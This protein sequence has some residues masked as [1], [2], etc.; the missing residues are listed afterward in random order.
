LDQLSKSKSLPD[1]N[2]NGAVQTASTT[3]PMEANTTLLIPPQEVLS[4]TTISSPS[5]FSSPSTVSQTSLT[6]QGNGS[7]AI[8]SSPSSPPNVFKQIPF[9]VQPVPGTDV[10]MLTVPIGTPVNSLIRNAIN[11]HIV[12]VT[13]GNGINTKICSGI[14]LSDSSVLT[15]ANCVRNSRTA[16]IFWNGKTF[17][18]NEI[19]LHPDNKYGSTSKNNDVALLFL[20]FL[21]KGSAM[22]LRSLRADRSKRLF[23]NRLH[24][25]GWTSKNEVMATAVNVLRD[26]Y[27]IVYQTYQFTAQHICTEGRDSIDFRE[28]SVLFTINQ[29]GNVILLG[30]LNL[31][32]PTTEK[33][34]M[35][36]II[37]LEK[38]WGW[39]MDEIVGR[40]IQYRDWY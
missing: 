40:I 27:C 8:I 9:T 23:I 7:T 22:L 34:R 16:E 15:T 30:L 36:G 35:Y 1:E 14:K 32:F 11:K 20:D 12:T 38:H 26:G 28:G 21:T 2:V 25:V 33:G 3:S 6:I 13:V 24:L 39:L 4:T 37:D 5:E 19:A 17:T 18:S 29:Y 31:D 10:R